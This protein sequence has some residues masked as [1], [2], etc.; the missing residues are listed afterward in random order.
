[1][2]SSSSFCPSSQTMPYFMNAFPLKVIPRSTDLVYHLGTI[3][4][5]MGSWIFSCIVRAKCSILIS[6]Y[7]KPIGQV[8]IILFLIKNIL[9]FSH[10]LLLCTNI[11]N[12]IVGKNWS[13]YTL[14][15]EAPQLPQLSTLLRIRRTSVNSSAENFLLNRF[16]WGP[17]S[18]CERE[19]GDWC[20]G[21]FPSRL[22]LTR[23]F[24]DVQH[25]TNV[26]CPSRRPFPFMP[27]LW[28][29]TWA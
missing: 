11:R 9:I 27:I 21:P 15:L 28:P 25:R 22:T 14:L 18:P 29:I 2:S 5:N 26:Y 7:K 3:L 10:S 24:W 4:M 13:F 23:V 6:E 16:R 20:F 17:R 19:L 8:A 12:T 1:M